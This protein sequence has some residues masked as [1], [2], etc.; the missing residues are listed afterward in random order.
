MGCTVSRRGVAS[1][2]REIIFKFGFPCQDLLSKH[3]LLV[4]EQDYGNG[5]QKSDTEGERGKV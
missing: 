5:S 3:V 2:F 1:V 4:Q